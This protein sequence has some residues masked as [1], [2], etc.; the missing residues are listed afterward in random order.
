VDVINKSRDPISSRGKLLVIEARNNVG[1]SESCSGAA[2]IHESMRLFWL[3]SACSQS[4]TIQASG[5]G[6]VRIA[7]KY[8]SPDD[9]H[10]KDQH[11]K[12]DEESV[13]VDRDERSPMQ[14]VKSKLDAL[15]KELEFLAQG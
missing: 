9:Q 4:L 1:K 5:L 12:P 11:D 14:R 3:C 10:D 7:L 15:I 6:R 2:K 13:P 8:N